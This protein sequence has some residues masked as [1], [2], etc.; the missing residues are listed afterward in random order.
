MLI[1]NFKNFSD[2]DKGREGGWK[3][4]CQWCGVSDRPEILLYPWLGLKYR[5]GRNP[6]TGI[7]YHL[8][9]PCIGAF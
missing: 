9:C 4:P 1:K 6:E 8:H 5:K 3:E 7:G 2:N